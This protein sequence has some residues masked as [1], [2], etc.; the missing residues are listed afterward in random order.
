MLSSTVLSSFLVFAI[1]AT[2]ALAYPAEDKNQTFIEIITT[3]DITKL[4]DLPKGAVLIPLSQN[5]QTR[6]TRYTFGKR[7]SKDDCVDWNGS[8][9]K[10]RTPRNV[11][12]NVRYPLA[13]IGKVITYIQID[14]DD[15]S[16]NQRV[17]ITSGGIGERN[18]AFVIESKNTL[19]FTYY[20]R[21][22][23]Q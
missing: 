13:G 4:N 7:T 11:Q 2:T 12:Q 16:N 22:Y 3:D 23:G 8:T 6:G 17:Y 14:V 15:S 1:L 19:Y 20:Y 10:Y 5:P 18:V 21:I 9:A